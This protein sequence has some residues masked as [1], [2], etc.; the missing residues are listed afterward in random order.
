MVLIKPRKTKARSDATYSL[1]ALLL[2]SRTEYVLD[3]MIP[4]V[5]KVSYEQVL[6]CSTP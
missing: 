5:S 6:L 4:G 1:L 2:Q 3:V